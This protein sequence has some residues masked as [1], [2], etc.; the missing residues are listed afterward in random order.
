MRQEG[1]RRKLAVE[2]YAV[3]DHS[4]PSMLG[5]YL[6][7]P[8]PPERLAPSASEAARRWSLSGVYGLDAFP[9]HTDAALSSTP[10]RWFLLAAS[11]ITRPTW[12]EILKPDGDLLAGMKRTLLRATDHRQ[13]TQYLPAAVPEQ[14]GIHRLRWD[15]RTCKPVSGLSIED[16]A[17]AEPSDRINWRIGRILIVDN[18]LVLHRRPAVAEGE[19]RVLERTY[20]WSR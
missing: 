8:G 13:R 3:V 18:A 17:T 14:G 4:N 19:Q 12:T 6:G 16:V 5:N 10:P 15:P 2:G 1:W 20:I 7:R 11:Q 9:W